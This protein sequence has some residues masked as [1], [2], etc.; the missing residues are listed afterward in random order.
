MF[1]VR[2]AKASDMPAL[3]EMIGML[4]PTTH[5][6]ELPGDIYLV[7]ERGGLPVGFCHY[8]IREKSCFIAGLGVL[9]QYREHG[10]GSKL[11]AEALYH[12]DR[13]GV[14]RTYLKVRAVNHAAKLYVNFGFFERKAGDTITLVR[15]RPS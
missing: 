5:I 3:R 8:R 1:S 9:V 11:M 10:V 13:R 4:F 12:A 14:Q 2:K 7:A 15:K 6:R